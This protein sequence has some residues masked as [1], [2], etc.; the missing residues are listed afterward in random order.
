MQNQLILLGTQGCHLC[1][2]A[3]H[4]LQT[5]DVSY[6]YL[7]IMD[8]E[9]LLAQYEIHIPVLLESMASEKGLY[10]PFDA[11]MVSAWLKQ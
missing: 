6:Q 9:K 2:Q 5:L 10:W 8:N 1:D 3:E 7:D 11:D 4:I